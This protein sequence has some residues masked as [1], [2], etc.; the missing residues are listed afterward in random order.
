MRNFIIIKKQGS[1]YIVWTLSLGGSYLTPMRTIVLATKR[2]YYPCYG[3]LRLCRESVPLSDSTNVS[4]GWISVKRVALSF[5]HF[6]L[7]FTE[8]EGPENDMSKMHTNSSGS[9]WI[10]KREV[11]IDDFGGVFVTA[12]GH[13]RLVDSLNIT[14]TAR[15][16]C[17]KWP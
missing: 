17:V 16:L 6:P 9:K 7:R 14:V 15:G 12:F 4:I 1:Y 2:G 11:T 5:I 3:P 10:L 13:P 8:S